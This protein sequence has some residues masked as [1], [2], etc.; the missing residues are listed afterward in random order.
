MADI[1]DQ[2]GAAQANLVQ[3]GNGG[4]SSISSS[5]V[6]A[7]PA[8]T[9]T[10]PPNTTASRTSDEAYSR[11]YPEEPRTAGSGPPPYI[12]NSQNA[13]VNG[14]YSGNM[15]QYQGRPHAAP[16][17]SSYG[18][19]P[20][21]AHSQQYGMSY[22]GRPPPGMQNGYH[23]HYA[24]YGVPAALPSPN[25]NGA[26]SAPNI[27]RNLIGQT[28]SNCHRL[29]DMDDKHGLYFCFPDLS[30]RSEDWFRLKFSFLDIGRQL[31]FPPT[32]NATAQPQEGIFAGQ[33]A[34]SAP[35][36]AAVWSNP[37]RVYSAKKF[38][39][40]ADSTPLS[41][42]FAS[43]GLK[44]SIRKDPDAGGGKRKGKRKAGQMDGES[45]SDD[46]DE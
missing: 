33:V 43:Q 9:L 45:D 28:T 21:Q 35:C 38:P 14:Q 22:P 32:P 2:K 16:Y 19:P 26:S 17:S 8:Q 25:E 11:I 1:Y 13:P 15:P 27:S 31:M 7:Y 6:T 24:A 23:Q 37:F 18:P 29:Q 39:G 36:L 20:P 5:I 12:N 44:I 34:N 40:V 10:A 42:K 46:D 3:G 41:K 30:V 4:S